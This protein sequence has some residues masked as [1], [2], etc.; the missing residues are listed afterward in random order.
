M[1]DKLAILPIM[2]A[3]TKISLILWIVSKETDVL[4][5]FTKASFEP[6]KAPLKRLT[7]STVFVLAL[8]SGKCRSEIHSWLN[9][10]IR[11]Q[12][13]WS[14]QS[15]SP[16]PSFLLKN[17]LALRYYLDRTPDLRQNKEL[18]FVSFKKDFDKDISPA[19]I[20]S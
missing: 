13:D 11:H 19:T 17:Q 7:F 1:I 16:S 10:N 2:S 12:T 6:F 15:L 5:Q 3:R 20:S 9:K 4:Q 14:K 18:V 8:A